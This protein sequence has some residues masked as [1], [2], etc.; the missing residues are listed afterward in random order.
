MSGAKIIRS[1]SIFDLVNIHYPNTL[2]TT[3][4]SIP[5]NPIPFATPLVGN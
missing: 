1:R 2:F 3:P 4:S 5:L